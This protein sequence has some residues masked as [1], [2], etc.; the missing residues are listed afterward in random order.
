MV[1][2]VPQICLVADCVVLSCRKA[3]RLKR[4]EMLI[5]CTETAINYILL[6]GFR[7]LF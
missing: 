3:P 4:V 6:L 5:I 7:A 2:K 1:A